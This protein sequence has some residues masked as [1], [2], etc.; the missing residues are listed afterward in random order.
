[1]ESTNVPR[2]SEANMATRSLPFHQ[3]LPNCD[4]TFARAHLRLHTLRHTPINPETRSFASCYLV[5]T[6][7]V[8]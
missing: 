1:M 8:S 6:S 2:Y 3:P 5:P 4:C 7:K